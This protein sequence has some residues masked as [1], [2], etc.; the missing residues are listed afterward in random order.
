MTTPSTPAAPS[1]PTA[2]G[3][4]PTLTTQ[5][6]LRLAATVSLGLALFLAMGEL[7]RL[8]GDLL[9]GQ[10]RSWPLNDLMGPGRLLNW[11]AEG[12]QATGFAD[13][14]RLELWLRS[15]LLLDLGFILLYAAVLRR[16]LGSW[17]TDL[18]VLIVADVVENILAFAAG[19]GDGQAWTA[20]IPYISF[21]KWAAALVIVARAVKRLI[22]PEQ[23]APLRAG[24][25]RLRRALYLHRFSLLPLLPV[26]A[27]GLVSG[28]NLLDQLPDVVR[29]WRGNGGTG[30]Q[31]YGA[32]AL[33]LL[34]LSA[35][36]FVLG[37][38]RSD[39]A[40]VRATAGEQDQ[41]PRPELRI[42]LLGPAFVLVGAL[43]VGFQGVIW[44]RVAAFA[45]IPVA[46]VL[47]SLWARRRGPGPRP[48][49]RA[50]DPG[51]VPAITATGDLLAWAPL[52]IGGLALIRSYTAVA[53]LDSLTDPFVL[54]ALLVGLLGATGGWW[55]GAGLAG[56]VG[57]L[58]GLRENLTVGAAGS[59]SSRARWVAVF[60]WLGCFIAIAALPILAAR[61]LGVIAVVLLTLS[62]LSLMI[63]SFVVLAQDGGA[64]EIFWKLD[65]R[66]APITLLLLIALVI[67]GFA[68]GVAQV[69]GQRAL[70][71]SSGTPVP[72]RSTVP[73]AYAQWLA[74]PD[75]CRHQDGDITLRPLL[76]IAAEGGG[77][78]A[79]YWSAG[80][81]DLMVAAAPCADAATLFSGGA[82][83]GAVGLTAARY[84][85]AGQARD[86]VAIMAGPTALAANATG[87][88]DRDIV[89]AAS[90]VPA[91]AFGDSGVS[92]RL[93]ATGD[94]GWAD[95]AALMEAVWESEAPVLA[96]GFLAP[97][98]PLES[99]SG[100]LVLTSTSVGTGCRYLISQLDLGTTDGR[101]TDCADLRQPVAGTVDL[102]A[103]YGAAAAGA[104]EDQRCIPQ[105]TAATAALLASRF[106]FVMPSAVIGGCGDA[107]PD[108]LVDG[109]YVENTGL[110]TIVD[111]ADQW[112]PLVRSHN[113]VQ[114]R[115]S[116]APELVVPI[117]VYLDNGT[118]SDLRAPSVEV[119]FEPLVPLEANG[120]AK[121]QQSDAPTLLQRAAQLVATD[122]IVD[123]SL[124]DPVLLAADN[125]SA[126]AC[127]HVG[128]A[129][130]A[131]DRWRIRPVVVVHQSTAP[132]VTAPLGWT[133]SQDSMTSMDQ[134]LDHQATTPCPPPVA[135]DADPA[136]VPTEPVGKVCAQGYGSL[137]DLIASL[138]P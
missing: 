60:V 19:R 86:T 112:L 52:A 95:R 103:S 93:R 23:G 72:E 15:Y 4:P 104:G 48:G 55:I 2:A 88:F 47:L 99:P 118:G 70:P 49:R 97:A 132:T 16:V 131:I 61:G 91:P 24:V 34:I 105:L 18:V 29:Q 125:A 20:V 21:V 56:L 100:H 92:D 136:S 1:P 121:I 53:A 87:L 27:L 75:P 14:T 98:G 10:L 65:L 129:S 122:Q 35:G 90:G 46:I 80:A 120:R 83:G 102:L 128:A 26:A 41:R 38:M 40:R 124:C 71:A 58:P 74:Q 63:G 57:R 66:A 126:L 33:V 111:L 113:T 31:H 108:Q 3:A 116:D 114:L 115:T 25:V 50:L 44:T 6:N 127:D 79:A 107:P 54:Q 119:T 82:S 73:A 37:R 138:Q 110:G 5:V 81:L 85:A 84:T 9:D 17:R 59:F 123:A 45:G 39:F 11:G 76:L 137:A 28:P 43:A 51:D 106:P 8:T 130:A 133:L 32:A 89:Y 68:G 67:S 77:I 69:H 96:Q 36:L 22:H 13:D 42:Y 94:T 30:W 7:S 135:P 12:W 117:V 62:A 134:A 109:G 64:P 101:S 78:R